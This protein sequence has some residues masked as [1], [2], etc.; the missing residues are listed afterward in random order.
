MYK[1]NEFEVL[2]II[3]KAVA[4]GV[5]ALKGEK[6]A[7]ALQIAVF[8]LEGYIEGRKNEITED[9]IKSFRATMKNYFFI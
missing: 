9:D 6:N 8:W 1:I 2:E 3:D 4:F 7:M 5:E